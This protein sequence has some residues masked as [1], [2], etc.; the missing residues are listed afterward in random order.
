MQKNKLEKKYICSYFILTFLFDIL[1]SFET[2][3]NIGHGTLMD[4]RTEISW[5]NRIRIYG[6]PKECMYHVS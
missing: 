4:K 6:L 2:D 5:K 1:D 3:E